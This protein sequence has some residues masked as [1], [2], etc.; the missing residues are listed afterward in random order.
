RHPV[1]GRVAAAPP[2]ARVA[3]P[4]PA[5]APTNVV[6]LPSAIVTP[7]P[8]PAKA[9]EAEIATAPAGDVRDGASR[10]SIPAAAADVQKPLSGDERDA[11]RRIAV[12]LRAVMPKRPSI[13]AAEPPVSRSPP[14]PV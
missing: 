1:A 11:F 2:A 10:H 14:P 3:S 12:A 7:E 4:L 5:P 6:R 9:S 8:E 13:A